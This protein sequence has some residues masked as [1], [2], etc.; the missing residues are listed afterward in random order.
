MNQ[1]DQWNTSLGFVLAAIGSAVGLGNIWRFSYLTYENGGGAFL[2]P[3]FIALLLVGIPVLLLEMGLG[4]KA[5][6]AT[7]QA[8]GTIDRRFSWIGWWSVVFVMFGI[9]A[10]YCVIIAWCA[11]YF[12]FSPFLAW[13]DDP[14][15]F[16]FKEFLHLGKVAQAL[17]PSLPNGSI[18]IGL[19]FVWGLNAWI[20]GRGISRGIELANKIMIPALIFIILVLVVWTLLLP[21]GVDGVSWYLKPDWGKLA[22]PKVWVD[23]FTQVF[24]SLSVGFGI[25]T[26]FASYLPRKSNLTKSAIITS[27]SDTGVA[28]VAGFAVFATL[29]FMAHESGKPFEEVVTQSIGLA[30][31]AYPEAITHMPFLPG[32]FGML[33]FGALFMAGVSSSISLIEAFATALQ[34]K[35]GWERRRIVPLLCLIGFFLSCLFAMDN[36]LY[37]LDV[38]DHFITNYGLTAVV[39]LECIVVGWYFGGRRFHAYVIEV[40][41][42][43]YTWHYEILMRCLLSLGLGLAW[44]GFFMLDGGIGAFVGRLF[45][46]ATLFG[47]WLARDWFDLSTRAVIPAIALALLDRVLIADISKPYGGYPW[48]LV[49]SL[50]VG[51][52][53]MTLIIAVVIDRLPGR[54]GH[55]DQ[56]DISEG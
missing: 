34:D 46:L 6:A 35:F 44:L 45:V 29:G 1:R 39:A 50:G 20:V 38:V 12:V 32:L 22:E 30:F 56:T 5:Q 42:F 51:F 9:E 21:G 3:Y 18:L 28:F 26:A 16:F 37:W 25:M 40:S 7:P 17:S 27:L 41:D 53:A 10:Y 48:E 15:A 31:V 14:N 43:R 55:A 49:I 13:G 23:A 11:D 2:V 33:F 8:F 36:G 19:I 24:F 47:V 52:L 54:Q 4:H